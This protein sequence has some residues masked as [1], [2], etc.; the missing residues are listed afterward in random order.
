MPVAQACEI[1]ASLTHLQGCLALTH[2]TDA[3]F[4]PSDA[5][6]HLLLQAW[7]RP[8]TNVSQKATPQSHHGLSQACRKQRVAIASP[9]SLWSTALG[10]D[11]PPLNPTF[12]HWPL[13]FSSAAPQNGLPWMALGAEDSKYNSHPHLWITPQLPQ[14]GQAQPSSFIGLSIPLTV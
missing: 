9:P 7:P 2:P 1:P 6:S 14:L 12:L 5:G 13:S 11:P 4:R 3:P 10:T 8:S